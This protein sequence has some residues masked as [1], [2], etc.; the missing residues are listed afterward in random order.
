MVFRNDI[1]NALILKPTA[2]FHNSEWHRGAVVLHFLFFSYWQMYG[3]K[4]MN[5]WTAMNCVFELDT[6]TGTNP[7][8]SCENTIW[9]CTTQNIKYHKYFKRCTVLRYGRDRRRQ[10][11]IFNT[12]RNLSS[13]II[14]AHL[15]VDPLWTVILCLQLWRFLSTPNT[16]TCKHFPATA[17]PYCNFN[18]FKWSIKNLSVTSS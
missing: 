8:E 10:M 12:L 11:R 6:F 7:T 1:W 17:R 9:T 15:Q 5:I 2:Y 18:H 14:V 3:T 4:F 16:N 13:S